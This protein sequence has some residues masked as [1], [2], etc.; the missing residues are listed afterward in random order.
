MQIEALRLH[1]QNDLRLDK[2]DALPC[3]G[4]DVRIKVAFCGICGTD[5]KEYSSGPVIAPH[6]GE[7]HQHTGAQLPIVL[8]H[9]FSGTVV[10]VGQN[11]SNVKTGDRVAVIPNLSDKQFGLPQCVG[12]KNGRP[13]ICSHIA[14]YGL[15]APSGGFAEQ[16]VVNSANT[17]VLPDSV[18]L[19]MGALV[20]PLSVAWHMVRTSGFQK[21]QDALVLGAGPIG[22]GLL[23]IL[24]VWGARSV[25]VTEVLEKRKEQ[26]YKFGA[27]EVID[28]TK[29]V[30][31]KFDDGSLITDPAVV[32]AREIS[33]GGAGVDVAFDASG[34]QAT[35]NTAI[36]AVR[37][38]GTI[39]NVAIHAKPLLINPNDLGFS[40]KRYT[41]G[42]GYTD[43]DFKAVISVL[44]D[45]SLVA[46]ELITSV[47]PLDNIID[48][49]FHE[50]L[51]RKGNH[52]KILVKSSR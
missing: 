31:V 10:E 48:G 47:V 32:K 51:H 18:S 8:G 16:A 29:K 21:G 17:L 6:P 9:E 43:D 20:E 11:V 38:G 14:Y 13:N 23:L 25:L 33:K 15:N 34:L 3:A 52:I 26:A 5:L 50:L 24:K 44:G 1:G 35:L 4:D 37:P 49:A 40:E 45:G 19:K 2:I 28:P 46:D 27:D 30:E 7:K 41:G 36:A 39:F 42:I 22:L 12:C